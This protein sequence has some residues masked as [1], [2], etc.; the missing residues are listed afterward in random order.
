MIQNKTI[1]VVVPCFN[2]EQ[3]ISRVIENMPDFVDR[4]IIVDDKSIDKTTSIIKSFINNDDG[5]KQLKIF[6]QKN[7][8]K[9]I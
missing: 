4:I 6:S 9:F 2:E 1:A 8:R 3:Q 7:K 5:S